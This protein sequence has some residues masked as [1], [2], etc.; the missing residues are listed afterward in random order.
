MSQVTQLL[1]PTCTH[2]AE[3]P[4]TG[5]GCAT[6]PRPGCCPMSLATQLLLSLPLLYLLNKQ[7]FLGPSPH[8]WLAWQQHLTFWGLRRGVGALLRKQNLVPPHQPQHPS[9][10]QVSPCKP[11]PSRLPAAVGHCPGC[12]EGLRF[13]GPPD[14]APSF[15]SPA[16]PAA[17]ALRGGGINQTRGVGSPGSFRRWSATQALAN[18]C[19]VARP[20]P[21]QR[22]PRRLWAGLDPRG[23]GGGVAPIPRSPSAPAGPP[24]PVAAN[25]RDSKATRVVSPSGPAGS[26]PVPF[27]QTCPA[28]RRIWPWSSGS[29][30][31]KRPETSLGFDSRPHPALPAVSYLSCGPPSPAPFTTPPHAEFGR[32]GPSPD[33]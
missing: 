5:L 1:N 28:A 19:S 16:T 12:I 32:P 8:S 13:R 31:R 15:P 7:R 29:G 17:I 23:P 33:T 4:E 24:L 9:A 30:N 6:S 11:P 21:N 2:Q 22:E 18:Q 25:P 26:E 3:V 27:P 14:W 20:P 10:L